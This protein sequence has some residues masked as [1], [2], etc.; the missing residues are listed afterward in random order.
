[1]IKLEG[2]K[3]EKELLTAMELVKVQLR[4][5]DC[6]LFERS[7][8][9]YIMAITERLKTP[10]SIQKKLMQKNCPIHL[11]AAVEALN[12]I[13]G[14]RVVCN[15][16]EE[17]YQLRNELYQSAVLEILKEKDYIFKPKKSGYQSLHLIVRVPV[18]TESGMIRRK[19]E[20]QMRTVAMHLWAELEHD[21]FYKKWEQRKEREHMIEGRMLHRK[22][23]KQPYSG[24]WHGM[25]YYLKAKDGVITVYAYPEPFCLEKT[26]DEEK[27]ENHFPFDEEGIEKA[28]AWLN[29]MYQADEKKW[30]DAEKNK[31]RLG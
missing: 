29:E 28:V 11:N 5:C 14:L 1:M 18:Y 22:L 24:S 20:I 4:M 19:V 31:F 3:L 21:Q 17:I 25:R 9:G 8:K 23:D 12:D 27:L 6:R 26:P 13:A 15:Y 7:G 16:I 2:T 30:R 10:E